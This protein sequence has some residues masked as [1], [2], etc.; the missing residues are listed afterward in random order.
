MVADGHADHGA[1]IDGRSPNLVGRLE[2]RVKPPVGV[3]TGVEDQAKV[4]SMGQDAVQKVPAEGGELFLSRLVPEQVGLALGD[5]DVGVHPA[6]VHAHHRLGQEAGREAH[7]VGHLAGQQ[8]V[9][10]DLVGRGHHLGV[11][12]VDLELAGRNLGVVLFILEAHGPLHLGRGVDKLAQGVQRQHVVVAARVDELELAGF[13]VGALGVLAREQEALDFVGRVQRVAL[14]LVQLVGVVLEHA[15]QVAGIEGAVLVDDRAEDQHLAVAEH[16]GG[17][18]V[19]GA[20]VDAQTQIALLLRGEAADRRAVE[21]QVLR[22]AQQE[23]LV[24]VEQMKPAF[25]VAEQYG[26]GL[27]SLLVGQI[28]DPFFADFAGCNAVGAIGFGSQVEFFQ[29]LIGE[30]EKIA[31]LSGHGSPFGGKRVGCSMEL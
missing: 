11:A 27:D 3:H 5:R 24:V 31:V 26:Y 18:P 22:G 14:L 28:L 21:G 8:L 19:E 29:L 7:V 15:A 25:E 6:A 1:A 16:V 9:E 4:Q 13:V 17:H 20:P 12:V 2:V 10:L 30:S 23:L